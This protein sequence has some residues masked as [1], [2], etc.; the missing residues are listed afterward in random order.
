MKIIYS[1]QAK[2]QLYNI[3]KYISLDNKKAAI[4]YL[5]KIKTKVEILSRF[6]YIGK[7]NTTLNIKYIRDFVVF[8]YKIIYKINENNIVILAIYKYIDFNEQDINNEA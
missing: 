6:P 8:G 5:T 1:K 2:E 7:I 3:K 4:L